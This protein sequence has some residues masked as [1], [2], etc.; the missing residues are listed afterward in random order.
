MA[1]LMPLFLSDLRITGSTDY[2]LHRPHFESELA[3]ILFSQTACAVHFS[4]HEAEGG[5][6]GGEVRRRLRL[7]ARPGLSSAALS[8]LSSSKSSR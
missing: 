6:G 3:P 7:D 2:M 4:F 1:P 8:F 5:T